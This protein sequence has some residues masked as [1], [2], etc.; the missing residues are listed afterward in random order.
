VI[1]IDGLYLDIIETSLPESQEAIQL[2][3]D[4]VINHPSGIARV[5]DFK[6][7]FASK[8]MQGSYPTGEDQN[9]AFARC[10]LLDSKPAT[11]RNRLGTS[12]TTE[13]MLALWEERYERFV[14]LNAAS[15]SA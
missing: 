15:R 7:I 4:E 8:M 11:S 14:D 10:M 9:L 1:A 13:K 12:L 2:P 5:L 3:L 6:E